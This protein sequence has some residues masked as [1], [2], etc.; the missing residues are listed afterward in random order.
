MT[1]LK[2]LFKANKHFFTALLKYGKLMIPMQIV[3]ILLG[4]PMNF[5]NLYSPKNFL[6]T[7]IETKDV[8]AAMFWI[9][10]MIG[11]G[12]GLSI[13]RWF[14]GVYSEHV[15]NKTKLYNKEQNFRLFSSFYL[16][17]FE[18]N[19]NMNVVQRALGY[20]DRGGVNFYNFIVGMISSV[21]TL[22][23]ASYISL[24]FE[25]YFWLLIIGAFIIKL[26]VGI[27][28]KKI[29]YKF[30][31]D[32]TNRNRVADYYSG[33]LMNKKAIH[34]IKLNN[35]LGFFS[36]KHHAAYGKNI[37][38]QTKHNIKT[39]FLWVLEDL[40]DHILNIICYVF[41]AVML[42]NGDATV[43]DYTLFFAMISQ[44]NWTLTNIKDNIDNVYEQSLAAKNYL[45]FSECK[46]DKMLL[47][48]GE[49]FNEPIG[50]IEFSNVTFRYNNQ[51]NP[52]LKNV[53]IRINKGEKISIVGLNGA[54]KS[55]FVKLI[56]DLYKP[57]SGEV[58]ING[59]NILDIDASGYWDRIGVVFQYHY[60]FSLTVA[61]NVLFYDCK[62]EEKVWKALEIAG[63]KKKVEGFAEGIET[64]LTPSLFPNGVDLSGGEKQKVAIA[65]AFAKDFDIY[66]FDEPSS[67]L[68]A[69]AEE[70]LYSLINHIPEDK[71][72]IF[73]SHRLSSV[74][75][76]NRIIVMK[77]GDI[78]GD[79][80]HDILMRN[81]PEYRDMYE[82]QA[83]RY[84]A[85]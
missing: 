62:D 82:T 75:T 35:I 41:I 47:G 42:A 58:R 9:F 72:V 80:S 26:L 15:L 1:G 12:F 45:E 16:S 83:R 28:S 69:K 44:I 49:K 33:I 79:N 84:G 21:I 10:L 76:T 81:C 30:N 55:T 54:G 51:I 56:M 14:F 20:S 64:P 67:A 4:I 13:I 53:N 25:W 48:S 66:I 36:D 8:K 59:K 2:N 40:P 78:I 38:L 37:N 70:E 27:A 23:T 43:G 57:E 60:V 77:D 5:I 39:R 22:A 31:K 3:I 11:C 34:E 29:N 17:Y 73:I 24:Q 6:D 7:I 19:E 74:S 61:E 71:T 52:A 50:D 46:T 18:N 32:K 68:D 85:V 65:R 63:L